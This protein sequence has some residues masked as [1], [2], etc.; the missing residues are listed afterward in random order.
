MK[1]QTTKNRYKQT[2]CELA[3]N[4]SGDFVEVYADS[5]NWWPFIQTDKV[6]N[7]VFNNANYSKPTTNHQ[8]NCSRI[9]YRL[10]LETH[11]TLRRTKSPM[12]DIKESINDEISYIR[13]DIRNLIAKIK[14]K[15]SWK[16]TNV[17]R[18]NKI[19]SLLYEIK[20]LRNYRDKYID[21]KLIPTE[22]LNINKLEIKNDYWANKLNS[23][24]SVLISYYQKGNKID[25]Q[26][27]NKVLT[28]KGKY[29]L[30]QIPRNIDKIK[31]LIGFNHDL[32]CLEEILC[33]RYSSDLNN[34]IPDKDS[35]E[36]QNLVKFLSKHNI[37]KKNLTTFKLDK[38][39]EFLLNKINR[40]NYTP[41]DPN[42]FPVNETLLE[43][44]KL[45]D[46]LKVI[47]SDRELRAEGRKQNH[48]IGSKNYIESCF[49]GSQA[50]NYKGYTFYLDSNL[51]IRETSG[52][53]NQGTPEKIKTEFIELIKRAS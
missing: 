6:G 25:F 41:S 9:L 34:M 27:I 46:K 13:D 15:G 32:K 19:K 47:K 28:R 21:K 11:L 14:T 48:C 45:D 42:Y 37:T 10:G 29:S 26:N 38:I 43:A 39:H 44:E 16:K 12:R 1:L 4:D 20:D 23:E 36:Y 2:N 5:Y 53:F 8:S 22:K 35:L 18:K 49:R 33:Y 51:N 52:K 24:C 40:K 50:A 7:I 30:D 31:A 3:V 17:S